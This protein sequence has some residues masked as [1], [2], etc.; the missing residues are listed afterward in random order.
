MIFSLKTE[1][2]RTANTF[3]IFFG[4][5]FKII[6]TYV[7]FYILPNLFC[8]ILQLMFKIVSI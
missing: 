4:S 1:L 8:P 5:K 3:D 2:N 7:T 6:T